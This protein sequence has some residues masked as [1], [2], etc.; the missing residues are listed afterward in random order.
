[1]PD[2][3]AYRTCPVTRLTRRAGHRMEQLRGESC[4]IRVD[5]CG[6]GNNFSDSGLRRACFPGVP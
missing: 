3:R 6:K 5:V 4:V 2:E 1:M